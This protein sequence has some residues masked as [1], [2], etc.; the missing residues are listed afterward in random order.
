VGISQRWRLVFIHVTRALQGAQLPDQTNKEGMTIRQSTIQ[1]QKYHESNGESSGQTNDNAL[2]NWK[3]ALE[4]KLAQQPNEQL[5][6]L[7]Q[8]V[9]NLEEVGK[10]RIKMEKENKSAAKVQEK[11]PAD[12]IT[13]SR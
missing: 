8:M 9:E 2:E 12:N 11:Q 5:K 4:G 13:Y 3:A 6:Q 10:T 1:T 7:K